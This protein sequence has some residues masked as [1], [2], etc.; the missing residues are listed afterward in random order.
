M[1]NWTNDFPMAITVCDLYGIILE[2]NEK[3]SEAYREYGGK[4]LVGKNLLA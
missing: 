2:M 4:D 1:T 3:A